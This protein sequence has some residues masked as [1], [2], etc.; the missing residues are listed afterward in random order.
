MATMGANKSARK[1]S[2]TKKGAASSHATTAAKGKRKFGPAVGEHVEDALHELKEG[3]L[4]SGRSGK[5][6]TAHRIET[7][8]AT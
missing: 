7:D 2:V 8:K 6:V 5:K 1:K 3:T 4:K